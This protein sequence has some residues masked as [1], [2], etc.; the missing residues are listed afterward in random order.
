MRRSIDSTHVRYFEVRVDWKN[1]LDDRF[2]FL[3][4]D[5]IWWH[6]RWDRWW[7]RWLRRCSRTFSDSYVWS[8]GS[9]VVRLPVP[10]F[11]FWYPSGKYQEKIFYWSVCSTSFNVYL[12]CFHFFRGNE[13][14]VHIDTTAQD[15]MTFSNVHIHC[16]CK[17]GASRYSCRFSNSTPGWPNKMVFVHS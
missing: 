12:N 5:I 1:D 13:L 3:N 15:M 10:F 14:L 8:V 6:R 2:D 4:V 9:W 7:C 11:L 17:K 16:S